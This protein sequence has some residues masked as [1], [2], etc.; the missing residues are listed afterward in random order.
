MERVLEALAQAADGACA[1]DQAQRLVFWNAAA[2]RIM[3]YQAEE[4]RGRACY[5]IFCG[6]PHPG[7]LACG[8]DCPLMQATKRCHMVPACN[9][10]SQTKQGTTL[11]LNVSVIVPPASASALAAIFLFRDV[12]HQ[13]YYERYV[14]HVLRAAARLP[15]PQATP[16]R[17]AMEQRLLSTPLTTREKEVLYLLSQGKAPYDIAT[18]LDLSYATVRNYVQSILHKFGAHSQREVVKLAHERHL[19]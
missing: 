8:P 9:L 7:C 6:M 12:T 5:E 16:A 3:G 11:L 1:V 13:L 18:A 15:A 2:E 17:A 10:L 14:E 4:V 19:V